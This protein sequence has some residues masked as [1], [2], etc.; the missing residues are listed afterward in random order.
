MLNRVPL[1]FGLVLALIAGSSPFPIYDAENVPMAAVFAGWYG[2]DPVTGECVGELGSTHWNDV[3]NTGGVRYVPEKGYYCSSDP[4][5]VSWQLEQMEKAGISVLLYSWW[6]WG[7]GDL[8]GTVEGHPDQFINQSLIEMLN[9]IRDSGR[10]MKVA[11]IVE[12]FTVTQAGLSGDL[13]SRDSRMVLD[14]VWENYYAEYQDQ[15][16]QWQGKPLVVS[17]DPMMLK[18]DGRYTLKKW[19]GRAFDET[20]KKEWDWSFAP[21]QRS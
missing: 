12:P 9:Q 5:V 21:P 18:N 1:T 19:T 11:L 15:M 7:D 13:S 8:D 14:Y 10:E 17:F 16:F 3:P 6:G 20:V 2:H 4:E